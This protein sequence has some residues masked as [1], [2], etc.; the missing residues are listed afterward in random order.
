MTKYRKQRNWSL[1]NRKRKKIARIDFFISEEAIKEWEY[2][3]EK[4]AGGKVKYSDYVIELF[5][6]M[7]EFYKL[8]Y[9]QTEG[10]VESILENKV[11]STGL[12]DIIT[13]SW[14]IKVSSK[15]GRKI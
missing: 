3:G 15:A 10:F 9:R 1:Y 2:R 4:K 12:Y 13:K 7:K 11:R 6:L 14:E 5:L 8:A